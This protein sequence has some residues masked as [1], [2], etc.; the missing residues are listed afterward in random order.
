LLEVL[1]QL[2][3]RV[4]V[5]IAVTAPEAFI[6][7]VSAGLVEVLVIGPMQEFVCLIVREVHDLVGEVLVLLFV[8]APIAHF[9]SIRLIRA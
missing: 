3:A 5:L 4:E 1:C 7:V 2:F 9:V 6:R 8:E